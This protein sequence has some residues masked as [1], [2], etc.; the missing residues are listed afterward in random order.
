MFYGSL[1][2]DSNNSVKLE[3][4]VGGIGIADRKRLQPLIVEGDS[5]IILSMATKIHNDTSISKVAFSW[6]I[7]HG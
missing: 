7:E 4:L 1:G 5:Q 2:L 6:H 3:V